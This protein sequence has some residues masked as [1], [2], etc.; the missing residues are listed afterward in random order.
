MP[1]MFDQGFFVREPAWHGLGVVLDDYPD[2]ETAMRLAGHDWD[3][4]VEPLYTG[5]GAEVPGFKLHARSDNGFPLHVARDSFERIP[6]ALAYD[7]SE[8]LFEQG[9]EYETGITLAEG[10]ICAITLRLNEP[11]QV[12]GDDSI[13]L[14]YGCLSWRHDG[15]GSLKARTGTIRQVCAN[16]VNASEAEGARLGTEFTFSHRGNVRERIAEAKE[17]MRGIRQDIDV[18]RRMAEE[19]SALHVTPAQRDLFV[20]HIVGDPGYTVSRGVDVSERVKNNVETERAKVLGL[21][22]Q[23]PGATTVPEAH[24]LTGYG[25]FLAGVEYFDHLRPYRE[26]G[27][28]VKRT[29]LKDSRAKASLRRTIHEVVAA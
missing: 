13:V 5:A 25:L 20:S 21:F 18:Y 24:A 3:V 2:R 8:I 6:N 22:M 17:A 16:T 11:I 10:R 19:L 9:F 1:A 26:Q 14:P 29:L 28:Y 12:P 15:N 4:R 27:S 7:V 23:D